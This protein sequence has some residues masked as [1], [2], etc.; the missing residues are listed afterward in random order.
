MTLDPRYATDALGSQIGDLLF[1]GLTRTD[2]QGRYFAHLAGDWTNPDPLTFEFH[3]RDG[4]RFHDGSPVT[5]ADVKA[6]FDAVRAPISRSP[7]RE[8]LAAIREIAAPDTLTVRFHLSEPFASFLDATTLG[9]LPAPA[10]AASPAAPLAIPVG[11]GP[12]RLDEFA[13]DE[14]V[15]L[16]R[17]AGYAAPPARLAGIVF[18]VVP[19]SL[20]RLLEFKR[21]E[22]DLLQNAI[23]PDAVAWLRQL[24]QVQILTRPGTTFQYLGMNLRDPRLAD[25]RVRRALAHALDREALVRAVLRG[26]ATPATGL[27]APGHWAYNG[28][29]ASY[30]YNPKRAAELLDEA[31]YPDPDGAGRLPRFR[32]SYKTTTVDVRK[33]IAEVMQE[34]LA[35]VGVALDI[36][37]YEWGTFYADIKRGDFHLYSLAWVG[38]ADPD[39][40]FLT[41]HSSQVPPASNNRGFFADETV[42]VL[43]ARARHTLVMEERQRLYAETQRRVAEL[44]PVIPLWWTTNVAAVSRRLRGFELRADASFQSL[45]DAWIDEPAGA[46]EAGE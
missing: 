24:P 6:T 14:R 4:F 22:L 45:R 44:L 21:G 25:V 39:I 20:V 12:F 11:S 38:V 5:A 8:S 23:E 19:D 30:A 36:R 43:T 17:F 7:K 37:T 34:Q 2:E 29:V 1:D 42:D 31:G 28:N 13:P 35:R 16:R 9:I 40:Y 46:Q 26:F 3:L 15:V 18:K 27:L 10:V 32:L 33:R 41:C